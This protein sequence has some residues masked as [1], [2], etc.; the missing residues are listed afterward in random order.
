VDYDL[1]SDD[2]EW[3]DRRNTKVSVCCAWVGVRLELWVQFGKHQK[4]AVSRRWYPVSDVDNEQHFW[5]C[6]L[7]DYLGYGPGLRGPTSKAKPALQWSAVMIPKGNYDCSSTS[8]GG[9]V[10]TLTSRYPLW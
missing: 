6:K 4:P 2:E 1:D 7:G 9:K 8:E 5:S 3:L 10:P